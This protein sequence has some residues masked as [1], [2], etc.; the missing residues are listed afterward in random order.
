[1]NMQVPMQPSPTEFVVVE[2]E[3]SSGLSEKV[4]DLL[5]KGWFLHGPMTID[6]SHVGSG[7]RS[8]VQPLVK[9]EMR[10]LPM[11]ETSRVQP[12]SGIIQ[13]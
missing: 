4:N 8:F 11:G 9:I 7:P 6:R 3:S 12:V 10:P 2:S 13:G 5:R 1:M